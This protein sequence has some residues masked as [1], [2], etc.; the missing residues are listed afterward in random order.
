[1]PL[2]LVLATKSDDS[3]RESHSYTVS[4]EGWRDI[5]DKRAAA[6]RELRQHR[7]AR[8][9]ALAVTSPCRPCP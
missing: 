2:T 6:L 5:G 7:G 4:S 8:T 1:V 3:L 9:G